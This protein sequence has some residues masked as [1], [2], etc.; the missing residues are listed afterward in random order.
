MSNKENYPVEYSATVINTFKKRPAFE[1]GRFL[2]PHLKETDH[3]LDFGC[4]KQQEYLA[5][6]KTEGAF[7]SAPWF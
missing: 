5:W 6:G 3:L 2:I 7:I 4:A 1:K